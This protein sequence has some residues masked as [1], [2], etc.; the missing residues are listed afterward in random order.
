MIMRSFSGNWHISAQSSGGTRN[1][2]AKTTGVAVYQAVAMF[3][4]NQF[5]LFLRN[6]SLTTRPA[7]PPGGSG[8]RLS[9]GKGGNGSRL[10]QSCGLRF[11]FI[12]CA[13][14][15]YLAS[16]KTRL[17]GLAECV[18]PP[19]LRRQLSLWPLRA[20]SRIRIPQPITRLCA[21]LAVLQQVLWLPVQPAAAKPKARLSAL[22]SAAY[23]AAFRACLPATKQL[24]IANLNTSP[25]RGKTIRAMRSGGLF[26]FHAARV[27]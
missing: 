7:F 16:I 13:N 15:V 2:F 20:A 22:F 18:S 21:P 23:R 11:P 5:D 8:V 4:D 24:Q 17:R 1:W 12:S 19:S 6:P 9:A 14:A 27:T 10:G 3:G 25:L 26:A